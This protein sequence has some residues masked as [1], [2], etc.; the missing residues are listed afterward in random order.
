M[1][2]SEQGFSEGQQ[3]AI[4]AVQ[5]TSAIVSF[6]CSLLVINHLRWFKWD[7]SGRRNPTYLRLLFGLSVFDALSSA[8]AFA[9]AF[10]KDYDLGS[11]ACTAVPYMQASTVGASAVYTACL[12]I[13]F[14]LVTVVEAKNQSIASFYEPCFHFVS[15]AVPISLTTAG[16]WL[17]VYNPVSY[18]DICWVNPYPDDCSGEDCIRGGEYGWIW[19]TIAN[20]FIFVSFGTIIIANL[21]IYLRI[22]RIESRIRRFQVRE[23]TQSRMAAKQSFLFCGGFVLTYIFSFIVVGISDVGSWYSFMFSLLEAFFFPLQGFF[24]FLV[25]F[26]PRYLSWRSNCPEDSRWFA[27]KMSVF[28]ILQPSLVHSTQASNNKQDM[29]APVLESSNISNIDAYQGTEELSPSPS[30]GDASDTCN[31]DTTTSQVGES[32]YP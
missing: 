9:S 17:E 3:V 12:S 23:T 10:V 13:Y 29:E 4:E 14:V 22:R 6:V 8:I 16:I 32:V 20:S 5:A 7:G 28:G 21:A 2:S 31:K 25:Y 26:R 15:I 18:L 11:F 24:N 1:S 27:F 19:H 30:A